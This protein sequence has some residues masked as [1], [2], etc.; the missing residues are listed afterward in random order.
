[1]GCCPPPIHTFARSPPLPPLHHLC[2]SWSWSNLRVLFFLPPHSPIP[3]K[4][5]SILHT[6]GKEPIFHGTYCVAPLIELLPI[7]GRGTMYKG[8]NARF[9]H[10]H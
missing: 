7:V 9:S 6:S 1:L 10:F 3:D 8:S 2:P 5:M 4:A